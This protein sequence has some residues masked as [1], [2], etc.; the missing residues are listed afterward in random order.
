MLTR[1]TAITARLSAAVTVIAK[2]L[3]VCSLLVM[4]V[5]TGLQVVCRYVF[6]AALSWP[7]EVNVFFM[8]WITF[9]GSSVALARGEHMGVNLFVDKLRPRPRAAVRLAGHLFVCAFLLILTGYGFSVALLNVEVYSDALEIPMV[10][11][12]L[13]LTAGGVMMLVQVAH[14]LLID[15]QE[16]VSP[17]AFSH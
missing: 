9:V 5:S 12:R 7:E 2:V 4:V 17:R 14:L 1:L 15:V 10:W 13:G 3:L 8:A 16:L 6:G 11:P